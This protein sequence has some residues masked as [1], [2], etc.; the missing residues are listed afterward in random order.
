M[1]KLHPQAAL[2]LAYVDKQLSPEEIIEA[3]KLLDSDPAAVALVDI[4]KSNELP[5]SESFD[6]LLDDSDDDDL[7]QTS[8]LFDNNIP[9]NQSNNKTW[10][11]PSSIAAS[12]ILGLALGYGL[13]AISSS[14]TKQETNWITEVANYQFLYVRE[15]VKPAPTLNKSQ[16]LALQKKLSNALQSDLSIPDLSKQRL[17]FKRGQVLDIEGKTLIQ[18]V[19][20]PDTGLPIAL[21][22]LRNGAVDSLPKSGES[23]GQSFIEWSKNGLSYVIIGKTDKKDLEAAALTAIAQI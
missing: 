13:F 23:R 9:Q 2:L 22:V 8:T 6:F 20:L 3:E 16:Q 7:I 1:D 11:W 21:C 18:L 4:L 15:T 5:F 12:L 17:T 14:N 19:Y 10:L